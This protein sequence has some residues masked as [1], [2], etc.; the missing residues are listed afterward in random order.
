MDRRQ[1]LGYGLTALV[2][3]GAG[4]FASGHLPFGK[5]NSNSSFRPRLRVQIYSQE[6]LESLDEK[7]R[8]EILEKCKETNG[9]VEF[10]Y[11][12]PSVSKIEIYRKGELLLENT[13]RPRNYIT[14]SPREIG[15][16]PYT[17][18]LD[19]GLGRSEKVE[20]R[21]DFKTNIELECCIT[22]AEELG[23]GSEINVLEYD[24]NLPRKVRILGEN[25]IEYWIHGIDAVCDKVPGKLL[26]EYFDNQ[27]KYENGGFDA[28]RREKGLG[29]W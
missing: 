22:G 14:I 26:R 4:F 27:D 20:L 16:L 28:F 12:T 17:F 23:I 7:K 24:G 6:W 25:G 8:K 21:A 10:G 9:Y 1:L 15:V 11:L 13:P 19:L 3:F 5:K 2:G 18:V 29:R